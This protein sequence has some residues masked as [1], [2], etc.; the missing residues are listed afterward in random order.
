[1]KE[2]APAIIAVVLLLSLV[3]GTWW[4]AEYAQK[5]IPIDPPARIT[6]DP[7]S[8]AENFVMI[9]TDLKGVA[10]NRLEGNYL[11]HY[12]D[13]DSYKITAPTAIGQRPG[14][15]ITVG[16]SR[17]ATMDKNG[18]RIVMIGDAHVHRRSDKDH[19]PLDVTSQQLTLLPNQDVV[20]TDH[21][22]VVINGNSKMHGKG[23]RYNNKT[24]VLQVFSASDVKISGADVAKRRAANSDQ[25]A[26]PTNNPA[27]TP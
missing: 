11:Q 13:D 10:I 26:K 15:P 4:A 5:S 17:T 16:T 22:A 23:M 19:A 7:D 24:Q 2:R 21:P 27:K 3:L 1:M 18:T 8:W 14:D 12:P 20:F 6:H 9:R 25:P